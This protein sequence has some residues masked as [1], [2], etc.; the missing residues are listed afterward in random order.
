MKLLVTNVIKLVGHLFSF[1]PTTCPSL[2]CFFLIEVEFVQCKIDNCSHF[3]VYNS[4]IFFFFSIITVLCSYPHY[5][6]SKHFHHSRKQ[7]HTLQDSLSIPLF[8]QLLAT[9]NLGSFSTDLPI[10]HISSKWSHTIHDLLCLALLSLSVFKVYPCC[11]MD[12]S[13]ITFYS[14]LFHCMCRPG[15]IYSSVDGYLNYPTFWLYE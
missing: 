3:K 6:I 9:T 14:W 2:H 4:V 7:A 11:C 15:F 1:H 8:L 13:L 10:L 5:L 12:Q